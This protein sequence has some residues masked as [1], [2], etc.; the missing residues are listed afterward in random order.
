MDQMRGD[1]I[2]KTDEWVSEAAAVTTG[3]R[4]LR[5]GSVI[6]SCVGTFGIAAI[7]RGDVIINQ[8]LQ[9]FIPSERVIATFLRYCVVISACYFARIGT[10]ATIIYVNQFGFENLPLAV[11]PRNEQVAIIDMIFRY[12]S[13]LDTLVAEAQRAID[14]LQERRTA[15]I[16]AAVTGKI[17]VRGLVE[18]GGD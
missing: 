15:L 8:Q 16:S 7:N 17:D 6:A 14:L 10:S 12:S 2:T 1:E 3:T 13:K 18:R 9:A 4:V 11:P 5:A